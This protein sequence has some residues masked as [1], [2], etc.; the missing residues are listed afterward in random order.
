MQDGMQH[1]FRATEIDP[2]LLPA[3]V[4]LVNVCITQ[5]LYGFMSPTVAAEQVT[6]VVRSI[7]G[8]LEGAEAILPALGW[9]RFHAD[10]DLSAALDAF[11][12]SAHLPHD[13][14]TTRARVIFALGRHRFAEAI[15]LLDSALNEDPYSPWLHA[16]LSWAL[17]MSGNVEASIARAE[18]ALELFPEHE[19]AAVYGGSILASHGQA[20]R[21]L[22]ITSMLVKR[23]AYFD[24][25]TSVHAYAL[26]CAGRTADARA[27]MEHMEWLGRER[28][29]MRTFNA[30]VWLMLGEKERA[31][32]DLQHAEVSRC[33]WFFPMLG[34]PRLAPLHGHPE[35]QRMRGLLARMEAEAGEPH[36]P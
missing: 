26:A 4:D 35:F 9:V 14:W 7:P 12:A 6:R 23:S 13:P 3:Q 27:E 2:S 24:L 22:E 33:P 10:H 8:G 5:S 36:T 25:A 21:A 19:G 29:V 30:A 28:F 31:I 32:A 34:D 16:R 11:A 20:E 18:H 1:L 15:G 17:Y